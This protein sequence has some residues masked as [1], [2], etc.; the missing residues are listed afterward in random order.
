MYDL[1]IFDG[2]TIPCARSDKGRLT[3]I[4][5]HL[6][7]K[8][9]QTLFKSPFLKLELEKLRNYFRKEI[10]ENHPWSGHPLVE[11]W[12]KFHYQTSH[13]PHRAR[14]SFLVVN[15]A[16]RKNKNAM[17]AQRSINYSRELYR[18]IDK[19]IPKIP[20]NRRGAYV[21]YRDFD[22]GINNQK[23]YTSVT[24][25]KVRSAHYFKSNFDR[26]V[27]LKTMVDP[28]NFF[29]FEQSIPPY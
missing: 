21:N 24:P 23:G 15:I 3:E 5:W 10:Q 22:S 11:K 4:R 27:N 18:I 14:T 20:S 25:T 12:M 26:L 6:T 1:N 7:S 28:K 9:S 17:L 2:R 8:A 19:Y 13:F 29:I 16:L